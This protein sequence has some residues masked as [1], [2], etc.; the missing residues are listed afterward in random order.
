MLM[1][2]EERER[3]IYMIINTTLSSA[4]SMVDADILRYSVMKEEEVDEV[5]GFLVEH[6]FSRS[7]LVSMLSFTHMR[8]P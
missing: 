4:G 2:R 7:V 1:L 6:F 5:L 3:E 8:K